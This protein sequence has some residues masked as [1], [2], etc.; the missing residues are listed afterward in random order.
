MQNSKNKSHNQAI[1]TW[2]G[3]DTI[4][5]QM[6]MVDEASNNTMD[7]DDAPKSELEK[8]MIND[9]SSQKLDSLEKQAKNNKEKGKVVDPVLKPIPLPPPPFL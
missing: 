5:L 2:S 3:K 1:T 6:P 4:D 9:E 7:V 8:L